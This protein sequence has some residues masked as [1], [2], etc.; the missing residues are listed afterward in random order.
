MKLDHI[1]TAVYLIIKVMQHH[2][3]IKY[4][5]MNMNDNEEFV[6]KTFISEV[7]ALILVNYIYS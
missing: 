5:A 3:S 1:I 7:E 6:R 2:T 4:S